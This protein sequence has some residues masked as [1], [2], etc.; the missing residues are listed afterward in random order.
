MNECEEKSVLDIALI[1]NEE[2]IACPYLMS[3]TNS[4]I[5]KTL[6]TCSTNITQILLSLM[7]VEIH[8]DLNVEK[9]QF[10]LDINLHH[11][12]P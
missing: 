3:E 7:P 9:E 2:Q 1:F 10:N 5:I 6:L 8:F 12:D 4:L 11:D